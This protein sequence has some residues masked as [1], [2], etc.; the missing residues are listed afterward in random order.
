MTMDEARVVIRLEWHFVSLWMTNGIMSW[1]RTNKSLVSDGS[2]SSVFTTCIRRS[3]S[4]ALPYVVEGT[5]Q[6]CTRY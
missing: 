5:R 3:V 2:R 6:S 1:E 4:E